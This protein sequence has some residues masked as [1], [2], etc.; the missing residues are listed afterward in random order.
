MPLV[1]LD[2]LD[3]NLLLALDTL[4]EERSVTR[5]ARRVGLTQPAMSRALSRLRASLADDLLVRSGR[6][7]APTPRALALG[8]RLHRALERLEAAVVAEP[9]FDPAAARRTFHLATADY[10]MAVVVPLLLER[11]AVEAPQVDI[12]VHPQAEGDDEALAD[13]RLDA[14]VVPRRRSPPGFVWTELLTDDRVCLVRRDHPTV[15]K[16]LSLSQYCA[17]GHVFVTPALQSSGIVDRA[18]ARRGLRRRVAVRVPSFLVAPLV[19]ARSDLVAT[20]A[21][22]VARLF[23]DRFPVRALPA[24]VELPPVT[25]SLAWHERMRRDA[26]HV[27]FRRLVASLWKPE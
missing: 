12:V 8:P 4:L 20:V 1:H 18:L 2:R 24:P 11:L 9:R 7:L 27:W 22:R 25:V 15:G 10:G 13:G 5:A 26:G 3:L 23:G 6:A 14:L 16:T 21:G 17:L 19:V